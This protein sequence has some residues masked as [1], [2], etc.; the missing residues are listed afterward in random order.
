MLGRNSYTPQELEHARSAVE[1][2]LAAYRALADAIERTPA[3][4]ELTSALEALEPL[5]FNNMA[6]VLDRYFVHRVRM[7]AG[8]DGNPLNEIELISDSLI[9]H[10]GV[11]RGN[12]V[13]KLVPGQTVLKLD[14]GDRIALRAAQ[15]E[16]LAHAFLEEIE[17]KFVAPGIERAPTVG[18]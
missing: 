6:L 12:T 2:Q 5:Y 3:V 1:Q 10:D 4:P 13:I 11:L 7:V 8:K 9:N 17:A 15:F 18:W 16:R 14:I